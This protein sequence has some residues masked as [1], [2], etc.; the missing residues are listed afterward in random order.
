MVD[1]KYCKK[2]DPE[3]NRCT[4]NS[5]HVIGSPDVTFQQYEEVD[6][7]E[8]NRRLGVYNFQ[9]AKKKVLDK[10]YNLK[11]TINIIFSILFCVGVI[12]ILIPGFISIGYSFSHPDLTRMQIFYWEW[13]QYGLLNIIGSLFMGIGYFASSKMDL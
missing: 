3:K 8:K 4:D 2:Y 10:D 11:S 1:C 5:C 12:M 13:E 6:E 7:D 9:D